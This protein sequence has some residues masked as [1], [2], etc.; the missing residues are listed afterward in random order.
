MLLDKA[1][2]IEQRPHDEAAQHKVQDRL[3]ALAKAFG[4]FASKARRVEVIDAV[5]IRAADE[6]DVCEQTEDGEEVSEAYE[7]YQITSQE[8]TER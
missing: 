5:Q 1:M 6:V 2:K 4:E 7:V 3:E 8:S